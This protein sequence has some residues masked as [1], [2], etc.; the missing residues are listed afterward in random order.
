M[1]DRLTPLSSLLALAL[2]AAGGRAGA[3]PAVYTVDPSHTHP[4]VEVDHFDGLS[5]WRGLFR[6]SRGTVTLDRDKSAG[7]VE[8]V[9]ETG[10]IDFGLDKL[11]QIVIGEKV[12]DWNGL[13]VGHFPTA[14]YR[15]T[16]GGFVN[17]APTSVT[18]ELTLHG[19]TRPVTL[20]INTFKCIPRHPISGKEV[21]GADA[22]GSFNRADFGVNAGMQY[23]FRQDVTLR[24]QIE[25]IRQQ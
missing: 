24:I 8:I 9:I 6:T 14:G 23:G 3:D 4:L 22:S 20:R 21:C 25:A 2:M 18:G 12:G 11:N 1:R 17:G 5:V 19:V 15:G 7:S 16:L 10:S 13:D